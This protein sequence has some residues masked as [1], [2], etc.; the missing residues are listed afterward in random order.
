[1]YLQRNEIESLVKKG[2]LVISPIISQAQI[3]EISVDFRLG[4]D[5]LVSVSSRESSIDIFEQINQNTIRR[6]F[7]ETRRMVGESFILYNSQIA[8]ASSLEYVKLPNDIYLE[9]NLKSSYLRLGIVL[10][11]IVQPGYCGCLSLELTNTNR[12][13]INLVVGAPLVQARF[14]RL[15]TESEYFRRARKYYCQVRPILPSFHKDQDLMN[16]IKQS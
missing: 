13:P 16:L 11:S 2:D 14:F 6:H 12:T 5:F 10:S 4:Y 9:L 3:G 7:Q 15:N 8:L 1:M